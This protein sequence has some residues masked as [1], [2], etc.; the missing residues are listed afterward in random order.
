MPRARVRDT[1]DERTALADVEGIEHDL[2]H[3]H[4]E[5]VETL[6][7]PRVPDAA[8]TVIAR[9]FPPDNVIFALAVNR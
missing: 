9:P 3:A 7:T 6:S 2:A 4:Q 1:C 5:L 8:G